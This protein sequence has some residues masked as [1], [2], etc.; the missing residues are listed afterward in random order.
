MTNDDTGIFD[1]LAQVW[2][3]TQ[4]LQI[5][6]VAVL[7]PAKVPYAKACQWAARALEADGDIDCL[8]VAD[9]DGLSFVERLMSEG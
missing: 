1:S 3:M 6:E 4:A 9:D 7:L 5:H 8:F 2:G